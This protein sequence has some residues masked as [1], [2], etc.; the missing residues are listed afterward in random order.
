MLTPAS[1]W[2]S[3]TTSSP[4]WRLTLRHRPQTR[5]RDIPHTGTPPSLACRVGRLPPFSVGAPEGL[6]VAVMTDFAAKAEPLLDAAMAWLLPSLS[7]R[8]GLG[9]QV[10]PEERAFLV[11]PGKASIGIPKLK[12]GVAR[13]H[14]TSDGWQDL[15]WAAMK[16]ALDTYASRSANPAGPL[17]VDARW[18]TLARGEPDSLRNSFSRSWALKSWPTSTRPDHERHWCQ[19]WR[20][21]QLVCHSR[22]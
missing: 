21:R 18:L 2:L 16:V 22:S 3:S 7:P 17:G 20:K 11:S 13:L 9:A 15:P 10:V 1:R 6:D 19:P 12:G 8:L 5:R 4:P 14:V